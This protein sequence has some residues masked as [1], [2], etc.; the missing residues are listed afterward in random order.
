MKTEK[1]LLSQESSFAVEGDAVYIDLNC[2]DIYVNNEMID[3][4]YVSEKT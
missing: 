1:M 2:G 3:E 4:P